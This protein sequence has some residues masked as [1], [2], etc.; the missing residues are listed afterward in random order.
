MPARSIAISPAIAFAWLWRMTAGTSITNSRT[1]G[2]AVGGP[3]MSSTQQR[4]PSSPSG[5]SSRA[6]APSNERHRSIL[7]QGKSAVPGA[8]RMVLKRFLVQ[9]DAE[10]GC[11]REG[12]VAVFEAHGFLDEIA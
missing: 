12:E 11:R 9:L 2:S 4:G 10:A 5:T 6:R 7:P 3:I 8:E 1:P